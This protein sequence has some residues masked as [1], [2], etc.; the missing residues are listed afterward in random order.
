MARSSLFARWLVR[1]AVRAA[2]KLTLAGLLYVPLVYVT[3]RFIDGSLFA[4]RSVLEFTA[5][6]LLTLSLALYASISL[7]GFWTI[8]LQVKT[9]LARMHRLLAAVVVLLGLFP[10]FLAGFVFAGLFIGYIR[11]LNRLDAYLADTASRAVVHFLFTPPLKLRPLA[12]RA[13]RENPEELRLEKT[14]M[15]MASASFDP[16]KGRCPVCG[17]AAG[18][19]DV[20]H[21]SACGAMYHEACW[22]WAGGC[23]IYGCREGRPV[24]VPASVPCLVAD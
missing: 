3:L 10:P 17:E 6:F 4:S 9:A 15:A 24:A 12:R 13:S 19:R 8:L 23:A 21:C 5:H 11:N 14:A 2:C 18:R 1:N 20:V 22:E 16:V 7:H